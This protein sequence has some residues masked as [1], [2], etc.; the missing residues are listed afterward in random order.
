MEYSEILAVLPKNVSTVLQSKLDAVQLTP[1]LS[2]AE[3]QELLEDVVQQTR[4]EI[5]IEDDEKLRLVDSVL[6]H[7][8]K[9]VLK[10][11]F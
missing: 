9:A 6:N 3:V 10:L 2:K 1:E 11:L 4:L 7:V 8:S 5:I